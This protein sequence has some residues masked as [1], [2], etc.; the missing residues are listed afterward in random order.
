[1]KHDLAV[2]VVGGVGD[3]PISFVNHEIKDNN[4]SHHRGLREINKV[5]IQLCNTGPAEVDIPTLF[6]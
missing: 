1:M 2:V 3:V 6:Q 5:F 4:S